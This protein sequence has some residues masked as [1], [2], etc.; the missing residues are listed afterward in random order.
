MIPLV[1]RERVHSSVLSSASFSWVILFHRSFR[2]HFSLTIS[3]LLII[4]SSFL[5]HF[6][7][8][9]L[10]IIRHSGYSS[11]FK[12]CILFLLLLFNSTDSLVFILF[13]SLTWFSFLV[14]NHYSSNIFNFDCWLYQ[15]LSFRTSVLPLFCLVLISVLR[16]TQFVSVQIFYSTPFFTLFLVWSFFLTSRLLSLDLSSLF[17]FV[18]FSLLP[19]WTLSSSSDVFLFSLLISIRPKSFLPV[20]LSSDQEYGLSSLS[21]KNYLSFRSRNHELLVRSRCLNFLSGSCTYI[22]NI[23]SLFWTLPFR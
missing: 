12:L 18:T 6:V 16:W 15:F 21:P 23:N 5:F 19:I 20:H 3:V 17:S 9:N 7:S 2:I 11:R 10:V 14:L 22:F 13:C 8:F 1:W 4:I